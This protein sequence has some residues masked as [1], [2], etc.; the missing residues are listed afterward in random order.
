M[1]AVLVTHGHG[2]HLGDAIPIAKANDALIVAPY[3]LAVYCQRQG[4]K[5]H[6]MQ[7]GGAREFPFGWVKLTPAWH[8]SA[9]V[10]DAIEYTGIRAAF[11]LGPRGRPSTMRGT[12]VFSG[13]WS[14]SARGRRSIWPACPSATTSSWVRRMPHTPSSC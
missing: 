3:E 5:A 8:G 6:P 12:L 2:D 9:V 4:A 1:D 11:C 14:S 7:I 10:D 13:T